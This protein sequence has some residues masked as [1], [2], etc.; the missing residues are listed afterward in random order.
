M[1]PPSLIFIYLDFPRVTFSETGV[2]GLLVILFGRRFQ[3]KI[4]ILFVCSLVLTLFIILFAV[5]SNVFHIYLFSHRSLV[6]LHRF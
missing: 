2:Q 3:V 1:F 4:L 5:D 6:H